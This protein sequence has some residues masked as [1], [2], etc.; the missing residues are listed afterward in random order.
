MF[1]RSSAVANLSTLFASLPVL[2]R[3]AAAARA[4]YRAV[5]SWWPF[6]RSVPP[7]GEMDAFAG[8]VE[9]AGVELVALNFF[10]GDQ[11]ERGILSHPART[12]EF[13]AHTE[14][15]R[16]LAQRLGARLF[17]VPYGD[18]LP[19]PAERDQRAIAVANL[20]H[21][22]EVLGPLGGVPMLEPL[23]GL[24]SYPLRTVADAVSVLDEVDAAT[25]TAGSAGVLL[26]LYHLA[27]S[28][29]DLDADID[30]YAGRVVHV[31]V[32]DHPGRHEP[33]TGRIDFGRHLNLLRA[34]GYRG[35]IALEYFPS[36]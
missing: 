3:P 23:S 14:V 25:G 6:D 7:A 31:Q 2:E 33:G 19:E 13:R 18:R 5:E 9:R 32:A 1:D 4:G 17:C 24:P 36:R 35:R 10:L 20:V 15:V 26:D 28:G 12:A 30:A 16:E 8:A 29:A 27:A 11:G 22:C 34:R 21:A